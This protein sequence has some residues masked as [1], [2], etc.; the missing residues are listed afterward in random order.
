MGKWRDGGWK[1]F[2]VSSITVAACLC[3]ALLFWTKPLQRMELVASDYRFRLRGQR[4]VDDSLSMILVDMHTVKEWGFPFSRGY[5]AIV[6]N[7]V[8][9][10]GAKVVALDYIFEK[11]LPQDNKGDQMLVEAISHNEGVILGWNASE[12]REPAI[13]P[14][15]PEIEIPPPIDIKLSSELGLYNTSGTISLPYPSLLDVSDSLGIISVVPDVDGAIRRIPLL[16]KH[17][18]QIYPSFALLIACRA[19]NVHPVVAKSGEYLLL[20]GEE[21]EIE[22]PIDS[23]GQ[24]VVNYTGDM[25]SFA[26]VGFSFYDVY[27]SIISGEP[28]VPISVFKDKIVIIGRSD[29][30]SSDICPTPFDNLF[31]GVAVQA[32]AVNTIL[33]GRFLNKAP[34]MLDVAVLVAFAVAAALAAIFLLPW[35]GAVAAGIL[36]IALWFV[37]YISFSSSG[38]MLSFV[39]PATGVLLSFSGALLYNYMREKHEFQASHAKRLR[40]EKELEDARQTQNRLLPRSDPQVEGFDIA[41][42]CRPAWEV[43]GDFYGYPSLGDGRTGI[44]LVDVSGKGL[45][46]AMNAVL[47][48][49]MLSEVVKDKKSCS[50]VLSALNAGL[51]P[52]MEDDMFTA[53]GFAILDQKTEMLQWANAGLCYPIVRQ[54]TRISQLEDGGFWLSVFPDATYPDVELK[55]QTGDFV[56]FYTDGITDAGNE[57]KETYGIQRLEHVIKKR[58]DLTKMNARTIIQTILQ[59][60]YGFVGTAEQFD[61]MTVVVVKKL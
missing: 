49:G 18:G 16:V 50:E 34:V 26:N 40:L 46:G 10:A 27:E 57:T 12:L 32:M 28:I 17:A 2:H 25:M 48:D 51:Y 8:A 31:P 6:T 55:L 23:M 15:S 4:T 5:H 1:L 60:V 14:V 24:M 47:V 3:A 11:E 35:M 13:S 45:K 38:M 58:I 37:S 29:P 21:K 54:G 61:D 20:R 30:S 53:F 41:G 9:A 59:D 42:F 7:T 22:V 52:R 19:L 33:Q 43:G 39:Q 44:A 36:V 56:V